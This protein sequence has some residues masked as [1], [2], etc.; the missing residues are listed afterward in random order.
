MLNELKSVYNTGTQEKWQRWNSIL[1]FQKIYFET[2][3]SVI[4]KNKIEKVLSDALMMRA[5]VLDR[6][7]FLEF[8]PCRFANVKSFILICCKVYVLENKF[9]LFFCKWSFLGMWLFFYR[10][11]LQA[12]C[13]I[14]VILLGKVI[15]INSYSEVNGNFCMIV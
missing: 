4:K 11:L 7:G 14:C 2:Y 13:S 5:K 9:R 8:L 10:D 12:C 15:F 3:E 1:F 6:Q